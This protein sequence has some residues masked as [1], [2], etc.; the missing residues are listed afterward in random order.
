MYK[1]Y[2][3]KLIP[4]RRV[5][6]GLAIVG[7]SRYTPKINTHG[8]NARNIRYT[9]GLNLAKLSCSFWHSQKSVPNREKL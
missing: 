4:I 6:S 8:A 9:R 2:V 3:Q 5:L 1:R 7:L